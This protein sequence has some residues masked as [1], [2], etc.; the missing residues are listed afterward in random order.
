MIIELLL[1]RLVGTLHILQ[2]H[3]IVGEVAAALLARCHILPHDLS[4][5]PNADLKRRAGLFIRRGRHRNF[6]N[7]LLLAT[8]IVETVIL[9]VRIAGGPATLLTSFRCCFRFLFCHAISSPDRGIDERIGIHPAI[10]SVIDAIFLLRWIVPRPG[11][12]R[13][14]DPFSLPS[15]VGITILDVLKQR[16]SE[17]AAIAQLLRIVQT[18]LPILDAPLPKSDEWPGLA[19]SSVRGENAVANL[20]TR[21]ILPH[22]ENTAVFNTEARRRI[23]HPDPRPLELLEF[24]SLYRDARWA[25]TFSRLDL[26]EAKGLC[27]DRRC[28]EKNG[29]QDGDTDEYSL[30]H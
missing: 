28:T 6:R 1:R 25:G 30:H 19:L 15:E 8:T 18:S 14:V 16:T 23:A 27:I 5:V 2:T 11:S 20:S 21:L 29:R 17:I 22:L 7:D 24:P 3:P 9:V 13:I 26:L 12:I 4:I 10:T